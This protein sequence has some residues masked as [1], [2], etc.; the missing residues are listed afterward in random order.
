MDTYFKKK[1]NNT[2]LAF[3]QS[4]NR[5]DFFLFV[6]NK[7]SHFCQGYPRLDTTTI[8]DKK[9]CTIV[10]ATRVLPCFTYLHNLFHL[11]F[12]RL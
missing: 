2:L 3:K 4:I 5:F 9:H 11:K 1:T 7:F 6:F 10:F 12:I 8:K